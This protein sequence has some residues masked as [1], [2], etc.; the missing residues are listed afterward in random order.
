MQPRC[1]SSYNQPLA[2]KRAVRQTGLGADDRRN[3]KSFGNRYDRTGD[4]SHVSR[5]YGVSS[6]SSEA[7]A[8]MAASMFP[9]GGET[10]DCS[11]A[12]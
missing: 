10:S 5:S 3:A 6:V 4:F 9:S 7:P 1:P 2:R 11:Q 8:A 12:R